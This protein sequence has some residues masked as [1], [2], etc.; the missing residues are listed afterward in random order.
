MKQIMEMYKRLCDD[1]GGKLQ[2]EKIH[3]NC[4]RWA[5][6]NGRKRIENVQIDLNECN[7]ETKQLDIN[8][9]MKTLGVKIC[10]SLG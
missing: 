4:W 9:S 3:C 8:E 7:D 5:C 6:E 10:P 2:M 1:T